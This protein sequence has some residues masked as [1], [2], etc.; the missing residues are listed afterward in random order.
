VP[1]VD[2]P[3][4]AVLGAVAAATAATAGVLVIRLHTLPT[5]VDPRREGVSA[6]A[7]GRWGALYRLQAVSAGL[8]AW[9]VVV[10]SVV[11]GSAPRSGL[12]ALALFGGA[13]IAIVW[14]P[15]DPAGTVPLSPSGRVHAVLAAVA[16]VA[17]ALAAPAMGLAV[18][19]PSIPA[20]LQVT[21]G[22]LSVAVP[23]TVVATFATGA[24]PR[25]RG[26]FGLAERGIYATGLPWL[27]VAGLALMAATAH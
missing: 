4:I 23:L 25:L 14:Y 22:V 7:L 9:F 11:L 15:T 12:I 1:A 16:F 2:D 19:R 24:D 3:A 10:G 26:W 13:R 6:Y 27:L 18:D 21:L 5:G 17:I 8:A 20:A